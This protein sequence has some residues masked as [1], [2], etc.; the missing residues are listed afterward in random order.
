MTT[1]PFCALGPVCTRLVIVLLVALAVGAMGAY[2]HAS[3]WND[4][5]RLATVEAL[6]DHGTF[7]I[8][9]SVYVNP[10]LASRAGGY[11]YRGP[12]LSGTRDKVQIDGRYYSDKSPLP[13][14]GMAGVYWMLQRTT[15]IVARD[16]AGA[17]AYWM[18]VLTSGVSYALAVALMFVL[19]LWVLSSSWHGVLFA[20][21]FAAGTV[22]LVYSRAVNIHIVLLA[23]SAAVTLIWWRIA[24]RNGASNRE[25]VVL[26]CLNGVAVASDFG[27][28][29]HLL[30]AS[31]AAVLLTLRRLRP[32]IVVV[33]AASPLIALHYALN[34][35]VG[36]TFA[37]ISTV[38]EFFAYT[39]SA[40]GAANLTGRW[41]HPTLRHGLD[42]AVD[43]LVSDRGF[44]VHN[45]T[46]LLLIP[47]PLLLWRER[48]LPE[49]PALLAAYAFLGSTWATYAA[50]STNLSGGAH[51]V[52]WFVPWL[53]PAY[54]VIAVLLR[55]IPAAW[56]PF[57]GL[58]ALGAVCAAGVWQQ[59]PWTVQSLP[60]S[61]LWAGAALAALLAWPVAALAARSLLK[62]ESSVTGS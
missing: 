17:F 13:G 2:S 53:A 27:V 47:A 40:F 60:V 18:T 32:A 22:A 62:G 14:V 42:Y 34:Y 11:P 26:G 45:P 36:G 58:S 8:D 20:S 57:V 51:T 9:R 30:A 44:L 59:G 1:A 39:G 41:N 19:G 16:R 23:C 43:M 35:Y 61:R 38:P 24:A 56:L 21:S 12:M 37:P 25:L 54:L 28:G 46:L 15:G 4:G 3:G 7:S 50:L 52:R 29:P 33:A 48:S 5:S 6:V 49:T 55:R 10:Q 31:I